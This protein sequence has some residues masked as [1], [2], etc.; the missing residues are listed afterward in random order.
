MPFSPRSRLVALVLALALITGGSLAWYRASR[1]PSDADAVSADL[2][3]AGIDPAK[4]AALEQLVRAYIL[5]HP[6]VLPEAMDRLQARETAERLKPLRA[7][8]E[9]PFPGAVLGNPAGRVV[10]VEFSDFACTFCRGA[11]ADIDALIAANP[12]LKVVERELPI[13]APASDPAARMAL[14]AAA[15]GKYAAYHAAM[16]AGPRPDPASI[17]A[18]AGKAGLDLPSAQAFARRD[19]VQQEIARNLAY[20][21]QLGISGTP[22]FAIGGQII[23]GAVGKDKLQEAIDAARKG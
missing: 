8:L 13:I 18:A 10:M 5:D 12:D 1:A 7:T 16:F 15:Q 2:A 3:R 23:A 17:A 14:A 21:R 20:A 4:R 9:T 11:V 6:E 22:A 19:E